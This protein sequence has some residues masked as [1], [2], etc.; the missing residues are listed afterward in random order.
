MS[1]VESAAPGE[2]RA[3]HLSAIV[4]LYGDTL[5]EGDNDAERVGW[6]SPA[7]QQLRFEALLEA[8]APADLGPQTRVLDVGCGLGDL[9]GHLERT[10][11]TVDYLGIDVL[12]EMIAGA[13]LRYPHARFE[14]ADLFTFEPGTRFDLVICSGGLS[15][16][17]GDDPEDGASW[18][19]I[20]RLYALCTRAAAFN[21][22]SAR[23]LEEIGV[24]DLRSDFWY[25]APET[26]VS[27]LQPVCRNLVLREDT[28]PS[29]AVVY[30]L[31]EGYCRTASQLR[32]MGTLGPVDLA[33][34]HLQRDEHEAAL[35]E[36]D[37]VP[38][39]QAEGTRALL[40]RGVARAHEGDN[41]GA[42]SLLREAIA[43]P[44]SP[45]E[46]GARLDAIRTLVYLLLAEDEV[47]EALA[48]GHGLSGPP[49]QALRR[50]EVR[51]VLHER[52]TALAHAE[53]LYAMEEA[54]ETRFGRLMMEGGRMISCGHWQDAEGLLREA[55]STRPADG[56]PRVLL[57]VALQRTGRAREALS[58]CLVVLAASP[59]HEAARGLA[60][61]SLRKIAREAT[62]GPERVRQGAREVL[63]GLRDHAVLGPVVAKLAAGL[64]RAG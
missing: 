63:D 49:H 55:L 22:Q 42:I 48:L 9:V 58:E 57:A 12:P 3:P 14:Q 47:A 46:G 28:V 64:S 60:L 2:D 18:A 13:R 7:V 62:R 5:G 40:L 52:L 21:V 11:R 29:D 59:G 4:G 39:E 15:I 45:D 41:G 38:A 34:I 27:R 25:V 44:S 53:G 6:E 51:M 56:R 8:L 1:D 31:R 33:E 23:G 17:F 32:A 36:L 26:L 61:E 54:A 19:F 35:A 20:E 43:R 30:M 37:A 16:R 10:G 50:D 24:R